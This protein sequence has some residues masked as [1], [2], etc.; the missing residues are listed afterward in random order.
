MDGSAQRLAENTIALVS[1]AEPLVRGGSPKN[2]FHRAELPIA[3]VAYSHVE[4][5]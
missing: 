4:W 5:P 3:A 2:A 1:A